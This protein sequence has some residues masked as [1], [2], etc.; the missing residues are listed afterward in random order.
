M[1]IRKV[2]VSRNDDVYEC[3]PDLVR[4]SDGKLLCVYRQSDSHG[5]HSFSHIVL[6]ESGDEGGTWAPRKVLIES[7]RDALKDELLKWNNPRITQLSNGHLLILCDGYYEPPGERE[8]EKSHVYFWWSSDRG[9]SWS[10]PHDTPIHGICPNKLFET[11]SGTWL[12]G[13]CLRSVKYGTWKVTL[14]R[15]EDRGGTWEGPITICEDEALN[16]DEPSIVQLPD[17]EL[18]CYM[19]ESSGKGL[20]G[21]KSFSC[22]EGETWEGPYQTPMDG[23]GGRPSAGLLSSGRVLVFYRYHQGFGVGAKNFFAYLEMVESAKERDIEK[24]KGITLP[25]D[26][27]RSEHAD[28]GYNGWTQLPN[29][30]IFAVTYIVDDA[31]RAQIRGYYLHEDDF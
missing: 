1:G 6:R 11:Q 19:R 18:V 10:G 29:G 28:L 22:D 7:Y 8:C 27:D 20:R 23:L 30:T 15:S 2:T 4:T 24:Q 17:R 16:P 21:L 12:V 26:H 25:I 31:P 14:Y 3:F 9:E 13:S 5:A